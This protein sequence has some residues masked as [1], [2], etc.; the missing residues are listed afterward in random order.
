MELGGGIVGYVD[1]DYAGDLDNRISLTGY[2]FQ[3]NECT[4]SW[5]ATL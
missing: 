4:V 1:P 3:V 5:K 2:A